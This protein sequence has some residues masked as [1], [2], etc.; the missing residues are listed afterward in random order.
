MLCDQVIFEQGTQKPFLLR[1]FTGIA[2]DNLPSAPQRFD[3]FVALTDGLGDVTINLSVVHLESNAEI[4]SQEIALHFP[5]PL[6]VVNVRF[7][8]RRL[9]FDDVGTYLFALTVDGE[10]IAA[11]RVRVYRYRGKP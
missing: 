9:I 3:I 11:R 8:V 5:D 2:V 6:Q 7:R 1:V 4:Y 10:E